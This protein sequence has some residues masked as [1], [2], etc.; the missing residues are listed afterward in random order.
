[1]MTRGGLARPIAGDMSGWGG[2]SRPAALGLA[3]VVVLMGQLVPSGTAVAGTTTFTNPAPI[4]I[5]DAAA[6]A[7]TRRRSRW[8]ASSGTSPG[9]G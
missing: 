4:A 7:P 5:G 6:A 2:Q 9:S 3:L 1:M 8:P